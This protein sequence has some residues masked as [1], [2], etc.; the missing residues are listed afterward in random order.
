MIYRS[1]MTGVAAAALALSPTMAAAQSAQAA[2]VSPAMEGVEGSE[3]RGRGENG[4]VIA[5]VLAVIA[6]L[7]IA[8][9]IK[10]IDDD[11]SRVSP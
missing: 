7:I 5:A 9:F 11:E 1:M 3:L 10:V 2:E 4:F 8:A 6:A